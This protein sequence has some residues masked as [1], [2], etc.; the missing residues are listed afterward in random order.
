M[1]SFADFRENAFSLLFSDETRKR[2]ENIVI[3]IAILGFLIHLAII[4]TIDLGFLSVAARTE[5]LLG[6]SIS[7]IYTPFSFI[8]M[9]EVY[10][11]VYHLPK[12]ITEYIGK[13][14]EIV[15][16]IVIR[17][18]FK[19]ISNV[20]LALPWFE[21][22]YNL[23]LTVDTLGI[24]GLFVLIF[25]FYFLAK[26]K[27]KQ[28]ESAQLSSFIQAK[29]LISL[30]L[31][32]ILALMSLYSLWQWGLEMY[33]FRD[34]IISQ[35][36]NVND[37]FYNDFF[38]LLVLV[39]VFLLLISFR[40]TEN[41]GKLIRNTGFVIS[42]VMI[43]IS[44]SAQGVLNTSLILLAAAFGVIMLWVFQLYERLNV[45]ASEQPTTPAS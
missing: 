12:S 36:T 32:P 28:P 31:L 20:E 6:D 4:W 9:Y 19:D 15:S 18:I 16:L 35:M 8:L 34:G 43:K 2:L 17:R 23:R 21:H 41:Y 10:L 14:Y 11:L 30:F 26:N 24:I 38:S 42:T 37:I 5:H 3:Y 45:P 1:R 27:M 40:Y 33:Q 39:D 44:F 29:K 22:K 7:A 13:Q 25:L